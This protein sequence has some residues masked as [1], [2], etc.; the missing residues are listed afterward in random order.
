MRPPP[1]LEIFFHQRVDLRLV[2]RTLPWN[3]LLL[4]LATGVA[5]ARVPRSDVFDPREVSVFHCMNRCVR[6]GYLLG[7]DA[8]SGRNFD[9]RKQWLEK[10]IAFLAGYFGIDVLSYAVLSNHFH[11]VLRNRPDVVATWSDTEVAR[12]WLRICPLRKSKDGSPAEPTEAELN[13]ICNV[14]ERL[15]E[16]RLRLSDISWMMKKLSEPIARRSNLEDELTGHFWQGR[17]R[18]VKLCDEAAILACMAYVDLNPIRAGLACSLSA[19]NFT[20]VQRRLR[21]LEAFTGLAPPVPSLEEDEELVARQPERQVSPA[22]WLAPL[23]LEEERTAPGPQANCTGTRC[24]DKGILPMSLEDYLQLVQWT[25]QQA[26]GK[27]TE[28]MPE[29][30]VGLVARMGI[31]S[32]GEWLAWSRGFDELFS[33]IAGRSETIERQRP[34]RGDR[35]FRPPKPLRP[36]ASRY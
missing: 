11:I 15:A 33:L 27:K 25:G 26:V 22:E 30:L 1:R 34:R 10:E 23:S 17:F 13:T 9:H 12:R 24:S 32:S 20:A 3:P 36:C 28:A 4:T 31:G 8:S 29:P 14:P 7:E 5:M 35:P 2:T 18:G 6:H 16:I 21:E 19:S